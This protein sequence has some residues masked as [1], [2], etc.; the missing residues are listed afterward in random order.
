MLF[1]HT[2]GNDML[3]IQFYVDNLL[4]VATNTFHCKEFSDIMRIEIEMSIIGELTFVQHLHMCK[5]SLR[6]KRFQPNNSK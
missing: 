6:S 1:T 5:I 3:I 4:F 2:R